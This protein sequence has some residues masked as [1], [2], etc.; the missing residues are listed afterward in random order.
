MWIRTG[1][2][3][4]NEKMLVNLDKVEFILIV[5]GEDED[6]YRI[7]AQDADGN[8][9]YLATYSTLEVAERA[10]FYINYGLRDEDTRILYMP[11]ERFLLQ[12]IEEESE[13][14]NEKN[15]F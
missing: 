10:F 5:K 4:D 12:E 13:D 6:K 11:M 15:N 2:D 9:I 8:S 7:C 1:T 3:Y 14:K